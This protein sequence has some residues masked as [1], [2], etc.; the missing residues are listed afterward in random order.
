[1]SCCQIDGC[2]KSVHARSYCPMHYQRLRRHGSTDY[3]HP[4]ESAD[5]MAAR[6]W[7]RVSQG[8]GCWVWAGRLKPD[9]YGEFSL[10]GKEQLAHRVAYRLVRG[11]IPE[12]K[13]I[14][15]ICHTVACVKPAHL[16]LATP[17]QNAENRASS[18]RT[19]KTGIRGV[20]LHRPSGKWRG[21]VTHNYVRYAQYFGTREE[22]AAF[23]TA[24]RQELFTHSLERMPA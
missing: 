5:E 3:I 17:K 9:G 13:F 11:D 18:N 6:F 19:S 14:D 4:G 24:R 22:A 1:M 8:D 21:A 20:S 12:G 16:R 23:V 7:G 10:H 2:R 15:H